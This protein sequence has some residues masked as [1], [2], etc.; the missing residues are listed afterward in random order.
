MQ[1]INAL[2]EKA[3]ALD[4]S[5]PLKNFRTQFILPEEKVYLCSNSLGL[6]AKN[7]LVNLEKQ[8]Q[9]WANQGAHGWFCGD[10]NWYDSFNQQLNNNLSIVLGARA[11]EVVVMNSLTINLHLLL[12]SFYRPTES[13]FKILIDEPA[14]P[15]DLYAIKSHIKLHGLDPDQILISVKPRDNESTL[16]L[17]DIQHV[18]NSEGEKI[19]LVFLNVVNYLTGQVIDIASITQ[20][21]HQKGCIMGVDIAHA[22]GNIPLFLHEHQVDFAVGC[23]YKY[24]CSGP[25]GPG[26]AF[27]HATHH[28]KDFLRLAGWWGNDPGTRFQMDKLSDFIPFGGAASWQVSTPS[29]LS[30]QPL[31]ASLE[32]FV[33]ADMERLR[34]KSLLQTDFLLELLAEVNRDYENITPMNVSERGNQISIKLSQPVKDFAHLLIEH[35]FICDFRQPDILRVAPSPLYNS[36]Q[37]I[38]DFVVCFEKIL[39]M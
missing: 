9:K 18:I 3:I 11:N 30:L 4:L 16:R 7:S 1:K 25:G 14:F 38:Y 28:D 17:E 10:D 5:D 33:E 13:R 21:A 31:L 34:K 15:S 27:V 20:L 12:T 29:I 32:L 26:I 19:A 37:D 22:A 6:P 23:S 35:G 36:F 2:R 8:M 24:L 39:S